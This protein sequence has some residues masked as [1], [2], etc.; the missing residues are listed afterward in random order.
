MF[1]KP[2]VTDAMVLR[3][4]I[5]A[6]A[7]WTGAIAPARTNDWDGLSDETRAQLLTESRACITAALGNNA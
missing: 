6:Y 4:A 2:K 7:A 3:G 5:A 1:K